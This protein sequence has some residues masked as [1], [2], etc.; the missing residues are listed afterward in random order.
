MVLHGGVS[1]RPDTLGRP[2]GPT[3]F[4]NKMLE[5]ISRVEVVETFFFSCPLLVKVSELFLCTMGNEGV[6][7]REQN[8]TSDA[9]DSL[10]ELS[11]TFSKTSTLRV[12]QSPLGSG[13]DLQVIYFV[14]S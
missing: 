10:S 3:T 5:V 7:L 12:N 4:G 11:L 2:K 1:G 14:A 9:L 8:H 6:S 13:A